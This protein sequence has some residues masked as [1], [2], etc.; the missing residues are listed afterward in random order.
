MGIFGIKKP[1]NFPTINPKKYF[2]TLSLYRDLIRA[3][4]KFE[5]EISKVFFS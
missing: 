2:E 4:K 3:S 5:P 1:K